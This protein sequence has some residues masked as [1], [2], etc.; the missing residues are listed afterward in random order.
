MTGV[1]T[2]C[3]RH[4]A[5]DRR[6]NRRAGSHRPAAGILQ[7]RAR[8]HIGYAAIRHEASR[9][10]ETSVS[11]GGTGED[12]S[13]GA[14]PA[15]RTG[16]R[17][18]R[19]L[20]YEWSG[21][22]RRARARL[23]GSRA[24]VLMYHRVLPR[25]QAEQRVVEP[26]MFVT[27]ET[28]ARHLDWLAQQFRVLPL[29]E[30]ASR[31]AD[32]AALPPTA[33]AITFDDGW[34]DN[35]DFALPA[36]ERAGLPAT[37]FLVSERVGTPGVFWPDEVSRRLSGLPEAERRAVA[38]ELGA[39]HASDPVQAVLAAWKD[40]SEADREP[41]LERLRAAAA[42]PIPPERELLD[43]EEV[44]RLAQAGID[45]ESHC[46][47]HAI[48]TG[49]PRSDAASELSRSLAQLRERGHARHALLAYPSGANDSHVR[50]LAREAG[51]RAAVTVENGLASRRSDPLALPRLGLHDDVSSTRAE[52]LRIVPGAGLRA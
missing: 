28:F 40:L 16:L 13:G 31:L 43:W 15:L 23:D 52:F 35:L 4:R 12:R 10:G 5:R 18:L 22:N 26:G 21:T 14:E 34:R 46:A 41:R 30:I 51:Y 25:A 29:H 49:L 19:A 36:L 1:R 11:W 7:P 27:P 48:L 33:C 20:A 50:E 8:V 42:D 32:G 24:A 45:L 44:E 39:A 17:R 37:I 47:T 2:S 3:V 38:R 6:E 9:R